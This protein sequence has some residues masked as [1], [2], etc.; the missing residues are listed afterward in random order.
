MR[1]KIKNKCIVGQRFQNKTFFIQKFEKIGK[2]LKS[3]ICLRVMGNWFCC[4]CCCF[5]KSEHSGKKSHSLQ[6]KKVPKKRSNMR[7]TPHYCKQM[8]SQ[9]FIRCRQMGLRQKKTF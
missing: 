4:C 5:K 9:Q 2:L 3:I 6:P 7:L 8:R 1:I